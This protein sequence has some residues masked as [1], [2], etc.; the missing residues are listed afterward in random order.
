MEKRWTDEQKE[1]IN[2]HGCNLLVSAAAGSGKTAV[3][4]ERIV[5][6]VSKEDNPVD[7]DELV[8]V[9]FTNAA[10]GEMRQRILEAIEKRMEQEP[11]NQHLRKQQTL[12]N[13]AQITTID[14]FCLNIIRNYFNEI[15]LDPGFSV[16]DPGEM[17]LIMSDVLS[18]VIEEYYARGDEQ[19]LH[20]VNC[21][22]PDKTDYALE[23]HIL[24][25]YS[26]SLSNPWPMEWLDFCEKNYQAN[27]V[28]ELE[29][30]API[31][32]FKQDI[33]LQLT[34]IAQ[35][36]QEMIDVASS[37]AGPYFY[38]D[39]LKQD[40]QSVEKIL[41]HAGQEGL[42]SILAQISQM[43]YMTMS[44]KKDPT[45]SDWKKETVKNG[46][47]QYKKA[48]KKMVADFG[49]Y[50]A[51]EIFENYRKCREFVE[52]YVALTKEFSQRLME[53]K[54]K[55][56]LVTFSDME[57]FALDILVKKDGERIVRTEVAKELSRKYKEIM[58][59]EYQDSNLV[60]ELILNAISREEEGTPNV[61]MVGDVK[62]SIYR[63]RLARP[64]LFIDK[65]S[66]YTSEESD[67]Q[68]IELHYNFRSR[69]T[70]LDS[71]NQVFEKIMKKQF[72][73]IEYDDNA[74]LR[75]CADFSDITYDP[76]K[77]EVDLLQYSEDLGMSELEAEAMLCAK[78]IWEIRNNTGLHYRDMAILMRAAKENAVTF[79]N[80]LAKYN[81][82]A[83][84][85]SDTGYFNAYEVTTLL[86][87]LRLID[88]PKQDIPLAAVLK[89]YFGRYTSN[90]LAQIKAESPHSSFYKAFEQSGGEKKE[91][92]L[93]ML[94][95]YRKEAEYKAIHQLLWE[96]V[97]ESGYYDYLQSMPM[98]E[99]RQANVDILMEKAKAYEKTSFHGLFNFVRYI[100]RLQKFEVDFG[101][102]SLNSEN[103][104]VVQIMTIH[105]SKGLEYPVVFLSSA[106]KTF[107][108]MDANARIIIDAD[109]GI[110]L[111][112]MDEVARIQKPMIFKKAIAK[113]IRL[114]GLQEEQRILY[115]AM[116]RAKEKLVITG[117]VSKMDDEINGWTME[118][119][120]KELGYASLCG[121]NTFLD[122]IM[123]AAL[124][125]NSS[126]LI[127]PIL[128]EGFWNQ[129]NSLECME[130]MNSS[131][132]T[133]QDI[134]P[135]VEFQ[136]PY[137]IVDMPVK[138]SVSEIKHMGQD[139][140]ED[141]DYAQTW[142]M[143]T[144]H[145]EENVPEF[146][147]TSRQTTGSARGSAYHRFMELLD[148]TRELNHESLEA[149][150]QEF[151]DTGVMSREEV[152]SV[153]L[154]DIEK[155]LH[156]RI[157]QEMQEASKQGLLY[158]E[159]QFV[160]GVPGNW[161]EE[162]Y[163][164]NHLIIVQG[165]IDAF[166]ETREGIVLLDYKTDRVKM[167]DEGR[168]YLIGAYKKQ[169]DFYEIAIRQLTGKNVIR[170]SIYS[171][172]LGEEIIVK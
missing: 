125:D 44:R 147:R 160:I 19:F 85:E 97:F 94:S 145:E 47:E 77:T 12:I 89:S 154:R 139:F 24:D 168:N 25:L 121:H 170:K 42:F 137:D 128:Q 62:Q 5:E 15:D 38:L 164:P 106:G 26:A 82:P 172:S 95:Y 23:K 52:I 105:K 66:R 59:D 3:L 143:A 56:N 37:E 151:V 48:L 161:V 81:I 10:A 45:V 67:H 39:M 138:R 162:H 104:D 146:M 2:R 71:T 133:V 117:C 156:Q 50:S 86:N 64:D 69:E 91:A 33:E 127:H 84:A 51:Q 163:D 140:D 111:N 6:M 8:I 123:P 1:V 11:E 46:R 14:S 124:Q 63:F 144:A 158:R 49:S 165:I 141:S 41:N 116:T 130:T 153:Q 76:G 149:M 68:K 22:A 102:A 152:D 132:Q 58:I 21:F 110:G 83:I 142:K 113:K 55:K 87:L 159:Q 112:L 29:Q 61:F 109:L 114:A 35:Q 78:R 103:D 119:N 107:N 54:R 28:E 155:F 4:V 32:F 120:S 30:T 13:H 131:E 126:F 96:I 157:G 75:A 148:Y 65:Y 99:K 92:F 74:R 101:E 88:N 43:E 73:G 100:E 17:K 9:T 167:G 135:V 18:Q 27:T 72:G 53:E 34:S 40:R 108:H 169:L 166:F 98:G 7:V 118:A 134:H 122:M 136:Y 57:H 70:V 93:R 171:F 150:K 79:V 129:C 36:I 16:A 80:V 60:Q 115:V 31:Q 90:E 20:F